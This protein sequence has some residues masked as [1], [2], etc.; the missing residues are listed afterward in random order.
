MKKFLVIFSGIYL[1]LAGAIVGLFFGAGILFQ[2]RS[3]LPQGGQML[4]FLI[5]P[6]LLFTVW[7]VLT[8]T[9]LILRKNWARYSLFTLSAFSVLISLFILVTLLVSPA[10]SDSAAERL[11]PFFFIFIFLMAIPVLFFVLFNNR[12]V[13][14]MFNPLTGTTVQGKR[15]FG[16]TLI[17]ILSFLGA[18]S[19]ISAFTFKG[20]MPFG[21]MALT[22]NPLKGYFILNG[23]INLFIAIELWKM[24]KAGWI[25]AVAFNLYNI[26]IIILNMIMI[27]QG[28][29]AEI[30]SSSLT[31]GINLSLTQYRIFSSLG[32]VFPSAMLIYLF[33]K[34]KL[35][36][37][38][39]DKNIA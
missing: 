4:P 24:H 16:I 26:C 8:G 21:S 35:F 34:K 38:E 20:V 30:T 9:G 11:V 31:S 39:Q 7:P 23:L 19:V 29:L 2:P 18:L 17:A 15:P 6:A 1:I 33:L 13:K 32:M 10:L 22:G 36:K 12:Q 25:A 14:E 3:S 5:I 27:S 28:L 37:A